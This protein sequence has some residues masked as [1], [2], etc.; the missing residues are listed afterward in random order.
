MQKL[1]SIFTLS[2]LLA[3][4]TGAYAELV[5]ISTPNS[6]LILNATKGER[7]MILHYG[8]PVD[9]MDLEA[10]SKESGELVYPVY[11][12][13]PQNEAALSVTHA[14]GNRTT[15]LTVESVSTS[16]TADKKVTTIQMK[17]P[18]YDLTVKANYLTREGSDVIE[19]WV[20]IT[21]NEPDAIT[22]NRFMSGHL[23]IRKGDVW[24]TS[25]QG[26]WGNEGYII[27]EPL[28][29]GTK[30][31][32][33]KDGVRN[34][35]GARAEA[36]FS[37]DGKASENS[38][39]VIG[40]ALC[41]HGNFKILID[42]DYSDNH[43]F[44][45][46]INEENS[47]YHL[48]KGET[49]V[50]PPLAMAYSDEGIGGI[51]RQFHRWGRDTRLHNGDKLRRI[52]LN[53][54]EG[55]YFN[56][57][58]PVMEK[59]MADFSDM[60]G[61]LFVM[62]DGWFG[63]KFQRDEPTA[64]GDWI[65][66]TRKLPHGLNG[67]I[68]NA[69]RHGLKFGL[70]IE[71]EM[72]DTKS[73]FF[74]KHPEYV[75]KAQNRQPVTARGGAQ[76]VLDLSN[77]EVQD[78]IVNMVDTLLS[79]YP[80]IDYIKWDANAPIMEHGSQYLDADRQSHLYIDYHKGLENVL[81]RIRTAHPDVTIQTCASG[82]G[83][84]NWGILPW[85]DE[86]WTSDNTDALQRLYIQWGTSYFYPAIAMGSHISAS[87]NHQTRRQIPIKFRADV[88]MSGRLGLELQPSQMTEEERKICKQ[89]ISDYKKVR[90]IVQLGDMY[91]LQS[92]FD[93]KGV[94]SLMYVT[95]GK[96]E[97]VFFWW[98][99][100]NN[101]GETNLRIPMAGLDPNKRYTIAELNRV[102]EEQLTFEGMT[103][104]G[105]QLMAKG[106]EMP[107]GYTPYYSSRVLHLKAVE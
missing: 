98:K 67:L 20:E 32:K 1:Y 56:I 82:G 73:V 19:T 54:W 16:T 9:K 66:D 76:L 63:T 62:D 92:P 80:E 11:G 103:L 88:A 34:A 23:P 75:I 45:A 3:S 85:F 31:I 52:L 2:M 47:E 49:F 55:V 40:A 89:A 72:T 81:N 69:S 59:M 15:D 96:E 21:N 104:T 77:P 93:N 10:L 24:L 43:H 7:L 33:N 100:D 101:V 44:F 74:E 35:Q 58:E 18:S 70:W 106:L 97:A 13:W 30:L 29:P 51:S 84:A 39:R 105:N 61:E 91:R 27:E 107:K 71:P 6:S 50:T 64:L 102:G 57:N 37:I 41:H 25:F 28:L 22:L 48:A 53:S 83:R 87:P 90:H 46:G 60:G 78:V 14:D 65:V 99:A 94:A 8:N 17:D 12:L 38:G 26:A 4:G 95:P 36:L 5:D 42:T 79:N 68:E 86:F